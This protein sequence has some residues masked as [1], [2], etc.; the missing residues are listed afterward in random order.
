MT[1]DRLHVERS[2]VAPSPSGRL[3]PPPHRLQ[4]VAVT[5]MRLGQS[6]IRSD[7]ASA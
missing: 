6:D 3:R 4:R 2:P 1:V 7:G 5:F